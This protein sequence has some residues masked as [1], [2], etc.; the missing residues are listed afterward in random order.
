MTPS[1][2]RFDLTETRAAATKDAAALLEQVVARARMHAGKHVFIELAHD[3]AIREQL[4]SQ[5]ARHSNGETLPLM[6]VPVAVKD[7]INVAGFPT[8]AGCPDFAYTPTTHAASVQRLVQAG[9]IIIGKTNLDQFATGLVGVRSPYG[10]CVSQV[11]PDYISGGS[12]SG[13]AL[14][15]AL[16]IVPLALGTDTAGSG[17]V[18]AAFNGIVGLKPTRGVISTRG[19]VPACRSLDCVSVFATSVSDA[20]EALNLL[21]S[22][23][24]Q[25]PFSHKTPYGWKASDI[26]TAFRFGVPS[27][28]EYFG[29]CEYEEAFRGAVARLQDIGGTPVEVNLDDFVAAGELLYGGPW[30]AER[31]AAV[32]AFID[33]NPDAVH[34]V[35]REIIL[36]GKTPLAHELFEAEYR[37]RELKRKTSQCWD[38]VDVLAL[39]T[40]GTIYSV[41]EVL[42]NPFETNKNLGKYTNFVNLLNLAGLALPGPSTARGLPFGITLLGPAF[43]DY[44]LVTI[45]KRYAP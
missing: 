11:N 43:S 38:K 40:T 27:S 22:Y 30:V 16:G 37:L 10:H 7:N 6:C 36:S 32:G 9:A 28:V 42:S 29:N 39:P 26:Q 35:V 1:P 14:A 33:Q 25:D 24:P 15:V 23:E 41:A 21:A 18:P 34:P 4:E 17:R 45:G 19:V 31:Y 5:R 2:V 3:T 20:W 12:S 13:S 8:T 44:Q